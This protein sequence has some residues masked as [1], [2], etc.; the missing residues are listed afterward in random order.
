MYKIISA[1]FAT[2]SALTLGGLVTHVFKWELSP[3]L[4]LIGSAMV[5]IALIFMREKSDDRVVRRL[6]IQQIMG[7]IF[8]FAS[9]VMQFM[10]RGNMWILA[11][12]ASCVF[13][14]YS[15]FRLSSIEKKKEHEK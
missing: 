2:G 6:Y 4:F 8:L 15:T 9:A 3:Y 10:I 11:L 13:L 14:L 7:G 5:A 12:A 1:I